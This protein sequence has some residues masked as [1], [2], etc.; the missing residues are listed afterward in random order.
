[1]A[2]VLTVLPGGAESNLST[3]VTASFDTVTAV[4]HEIPLGFS[5]SRVEI[6]DI[7]SGAIL[8]YTWTA[9]MGPTRFLLQAGVA[10]LATVE[11][12]AVHRG[13]TADGT[14]GL[15]FSSS[16]LTPSSGKVYVT[17]WR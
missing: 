3:I 15:L 1:M 6:I 4:A 9:A 8:I 12:G 17:I 11:F 7:T 2:D 14:T 16:A 13:R 10:T 5:P